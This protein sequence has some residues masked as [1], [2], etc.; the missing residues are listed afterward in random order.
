MALV[1]T[2][3]CLA[4]SANA[5]PSKTDLLVDKFM[6][7]SKNRCIGSGCNLA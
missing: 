7:L 3:T 5:I 6:R 1:V 2:P 4:T